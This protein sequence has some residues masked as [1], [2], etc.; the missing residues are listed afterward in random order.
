MVRQ[1]LDIVGSWAVSRLVVAA[2]NNILLLT[3][4]LLCSAFYCKLAATLGFFWSLLH[5]CWQI[6]TLNVATKPTVRSSPKCSAGGV[7]LTWKHVMYKRIGYT[8]ERRRYVPGGSTKKVRTNWHYGL[9][10]DNKYTP[11][12]LQKKRELYWETWHR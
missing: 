2:P 12:Y 11:T 6:V 1:R 7:S 5:D 10:E 9:T 4:R 8:V 3:D